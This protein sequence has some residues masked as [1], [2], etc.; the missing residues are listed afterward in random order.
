MIT[1]EKQ[2]FKPQRLSQKQLKYLEINTETLQSPAPTG[3]VSCHRHLLEGGK[4]GL[5]RLSGVSTFGFEV[6]LAH[7][8]PFSSLHGGAETATVRRRW[9]TVWYKDTPSTSGK[10]GRNGNAN[11][12]HA[13]IMCQVKLSHSTSVRKNPLSFL[14]WPVIAISVVSLVLPVQGARCVYYSQSMWGD[15][16]SCLPRPNNTLI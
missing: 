1:E 8:E 5:H 13:R 16:E 9:S 2:S 6:S 12:C 3:V 4:W 15:I 14:S 7:F 10:P 11:P